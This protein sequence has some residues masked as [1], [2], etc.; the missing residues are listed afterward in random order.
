VSDPFLLDHT[1][2]EA[3]QCSILVTLPAALRWGS[4][5][6]QHVLSSQEEDRFPYHVPRYNF[7][8]PHGLG[9]MRLSL[10]TYSPSHQHIIITSFPTTNHVYLSTAWKW[11]KPPQISLNQ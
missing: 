2:A 11:L 9:W 3:Q 4:K 10:S 5:K 7:L 8:L 6:F 1:S